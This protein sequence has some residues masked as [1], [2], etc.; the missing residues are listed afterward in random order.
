[1]KRLFFIFGLLFSLSAKAVTL[2]WDPSPDDVAGY[3][4]YWGTTSSSYD[5]FADTGINFVI[6]TDG[7]SV[8]LGVI[9][10]N[11]LLLPDTIYF[12]AVTAYDASGMESNF[13]EETQYYNPPN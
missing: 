13:S 11:S 6:D 9:L 3:N 10:D 5:T 1:M 4:I 7:V 12:F 8:I 2:A